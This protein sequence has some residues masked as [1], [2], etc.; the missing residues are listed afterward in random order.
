MPQRAHS[1]GEEI[2]SRHSTR[3]GFQHR[4]DWQIH[5]LRRQAAIRSLLRNVRKRFGVVLCGP[6]DTLSDDEDDGS[7]H[8]YHVRDNVVVAQFSVG[9]TR[10]DW[11]RVGLPAARQSG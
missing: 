5:A 1:T 3:G 4:Q 6:R 9:G 2:T 10:I 11:L 8:I 7:N